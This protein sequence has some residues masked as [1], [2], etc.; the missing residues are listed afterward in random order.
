[1]NNS[2]LTTHNSQRVRRGSSRLELVLITFGLV[3]ST[4][5]GDT[6]DVEIL[7]NGNVVWTSP[8]S[9]DYLA[10]SQNLGIAHHLTPPQTVT[11]RVSSPLKN[12]ELLFFPIDPQLSYEVI[13]DQ[14]DAPI[15][16]T[17]LAAGFLH[18]GGNKNY[19]VGAS[20]FFANGGVL[21]RSIHALYQRQHGECEAEVQWSTLFDAVTA[22]IDDSS[23]EGDCNLLF[24]PNFA[25]TYDQR[26]AT[27]YLRQVNVSFLGGTGRGGFGLFIKG[28]THFDSPFIDDLRFS[29]NVAYDL[30]NSAGLPRFTIAKGPYAQAWNCSPS[31]ATTC[32]HGDVND[33]IRDGLREA[34]TTLNDLFA[35]CLVAPIDVN[36]ESSDNCVSNFSTAFLA[37][38]AEQE[39]LARGMSA[40]RAAQFEAALLNKNNWSCAPITEACADLTG[41][42]PTEEKTCQ[43]K[44]RAADIVPMPD[45]FRW[46]GT[47]ETSH[48]LAS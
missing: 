24:C 2:Q 1:M 39:A 31:P 44:L 33:G 40:G 16:P 20:L 41:S 10:R 35:Q 17:E 30:T 34:A 29:G 28:D 12:R 48:R 11:A 8:L 42:E 43:L 26:V 23:G 32:P 38:A 37:N 27:S 45:T 18:P 46:C 22:S 7:V 25:V 5:C 19:F 4:A 21:P 14:Q 9:A 3:G 47:V 15:I 6:G 36:C 13:A